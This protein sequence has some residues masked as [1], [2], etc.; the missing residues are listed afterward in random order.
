VQ[1]G[2]G[3]L[4]GSASVGLLEW[5]GKCWA[6]CFGERI[7]EL[8]K[9]VAHV[10]SIPATILRVPLVF[11]VVVGGHSCIT[12]GAGGHSVVNAV[13]FQ[14]WF[15]MVWLCPGSAIT[16]LPASLEDLGIFHPSKPSSQAL[17]FFC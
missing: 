14:L 3:A 10:G 11:L 4:T 15:V 13:C 5:D 2:F 7:S 6:L 8:R 17:R 16:R 9:Y 1:R 12:A